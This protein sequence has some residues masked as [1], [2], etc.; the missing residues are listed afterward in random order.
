[1]QQKK[2][3]NNVALWKGSDSNISH[4]DGYLGCPGACNCQY[5]V[6]AF[7]IIMH[8]IAQKLCIN[9]RKQLLNSSQGYASRIIY[10][11]NVFMLAAIT[12]MYWTADGRADIQIRDKKRRSIFMVEFRKWIYTR[13]HQNISSPAVHSQKFPL[14]HLR[15]ERPICMLQSEQLKIPSKTMSS[16][17]E[18]F[19]K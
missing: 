13:T 7:L 17:S 18:T 6:N 19:R 1:M 15:G 11:N 5:S 4:F 9:N 8:F 3:L 12:E 2:S 16:C 14:Q 10:E